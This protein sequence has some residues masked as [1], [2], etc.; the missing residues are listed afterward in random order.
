MD[1]IE[2]LREL[3]SIDS[4]FPNENRLAIYLE[5]RLQE[6]GFETERIEV[7]EGRFNVVGKRGEGE[8]PILLYGHMDTVPVYGEWRSDPFTLREDGDRLYG[9]GAYDMKAGVAAILS[10]CC[11]V[12]ESVPIKVAFGV[13]EENDSDGG[14]AIVRS[15]FFDDAKIAIVPEINDSLCRTDV[16]N[17]IMLGRRGRTEYL[18]EVPGVSAHAADIKAGVNATSEAAKLAIELDRMNE[19]FVEEG[20]RPAQ[21]QFIRELMGKATSLSLAENAYLVLDRHML[22]PDDSQ[23]VLEQLR[24]E[25]DK[26]YSRGVFSDTGERRVKVSIKKRD[27]PYLQAYETDRENEDVQRLSKIVRER[28]AEPVYTYGMSTADECVIASTGVPVVSYAPVGD[29]AH[30]PDEW[31]SRK[32]VE[33]MVGVLAE[34]LKTGR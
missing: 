1:S 18:F 15:G 19:R 17:A 29:R 28:V 11:A 7:C 10:A 33:Q 20:F 9:L 4:I 31:V 3:V 34:F 25:V 12:D 21:S 14:W 27:S 5:K 24:E 2:T 13:D 16:S 30:K 22:K 32:S 6:S 26:M 8:K 23:S